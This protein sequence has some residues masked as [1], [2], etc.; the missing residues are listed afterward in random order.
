MRRLLFSLL[1]G[2]C[3]ISQNA[4]AQVATI[5]ESNTEFECTGAKTATLR[6]RRVIVIHNAHGD[7]LAIF[8]C[9]CGPGDDLSRF[10]GEVADAQGKVIKK[11]KKS[12]LTRSEYSTEFKSDDFFYYYQYS[13]ISYPVTVTYEWEEKFTGGLRAYPPFAPQAR[14]EVDVR[15]ASYRFIATPEN[16]MRWHARN[17]EPEVVTRE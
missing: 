16:T 12:E 7:D 15:E 6:E 11:I 13:P 2:G 9:W 8:H 3:L 10:S 1:V 4:D 5:V 14:Y 17:F